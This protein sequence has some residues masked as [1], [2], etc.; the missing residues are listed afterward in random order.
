M[1]PAHSSQSGSSAN[2]PDLSASRDSASISVPSLSLPKGGG[3]LRGIGEKFSVNAC[4]GTGTTAVPLPFLPTRGELQPSL[5]LSY[6]SGS[7]NGSFGAGWQLDIGSIS[8]KTDKGLPKYEDVAPT[9]VFIFSGAEDLVPVLPENLQSRDGY[10]VRRFRPRVEAGFARIEWWVHSD[11]PSHNHWR[12][13][14]RDNVTHILGFST[15]ARIA[16][17]SDASR[18]FQWLLECSFNDRG[19]AVVY[20]YKPENFEGVDV[21]DLSEAHRLQGICTVA[22]SH[23]ESISYGNIAPF[24]AE[25]GSNYWPSVETL[26]ASAESFSE[27]WQFRAFFDYTARGLE[28]FKPDNSNWLAR[29]DP[30]SSYRAGFEVRSYRLCQKILFETSV[31]I[32]IEGRETGYAGITHALMLQY[33]EPAAGTAVNSGQ[34]SPILTKLESIQQLHARRKSAQGS[35]PPT[36]ETTPWPPLEFEYSISGAMELQQIS[37]ANAPALPEGIDGARYEWVDLDGEGIQGVLSRRN[38]AWWYAP[39]RWTSNSTPDAA[40]NEPATGGA[41]APQKPLRLQAAT[42]IGNATAQLVDLAGDGSL[43][44]LERSSG[45]TFFYERNDSGGWERPR[46]L[47]RHPAYSLDDPNLR[48]I[49]L[50]GDGLA[51]LLITE[52][53]CLVWQEALGEAGYGAVHRVA[54]VLDERRGP[55]CVFSEV[56]QTVF[57]ADLSGDGLTDIIRIRNGDVCYWPNLGYGRFGARVTMDYAPVFDTIDQFDPRRI[58]LLDADGSGMADLVYLGR[59][60]AAFWANQS[61][62][63][64]SERREIPFPIPHSLATVTA[65]DFFG[66]G[67]DCLVWSSPAP[68]DSA[69]HFQVVDLTGG[70]KPH[71]LTLV[72]NNM[73]AE[74]ALSYCSS[75]HFYLK[76]LADRKPWITRLPFPVHVIEAVETRDLIGRNHFVSRYAY[77][78]GY[79][80]GAEREFRGFGMVEQWDTDEIGALSSAGDA[81]DNWESASYVPPKLTRTWFHHGA[82]SLDNSLTAAFKTSYWDG[83]ERAIH[84]TESAIPEGLSVDEEREAHRALRGRMLRQEIYSLDADDDSAQEVR[85]R[86]ARPYETIEQNFTIRTLQPRGRNRHAVFFVHPREVLHAH[87]ER[88]APSD[89]RVAHALTLKVDAFGNVEQ[90]V[91]IGYGR[92]LPPKPD[93]LPQSKPD[94]PAQPKPGGKKDKPPPQHQLTPAETTAQNRTLLTLNDS[95]FTNAIENLPD[96]WRT[97]LPAEERTY[98]LTDYEWQNAKAEN[99]SGLTFELLQ[100]AV[101]QL[102]AIEEIAYEATASYAKRQLRLVE[103]HRTFYRSNDLKI[104]LPLGRLESLALPGEALKLALTPG[105]LDLYKDNAGSDDVSGYLRDRSA[106]YAEPEGDHHFWIPS[107]RTFFSPDASGTPQGSAA[108]LAFARKRFFLPHRFVDAFGNATWVAYDDA[109][110]RIAE[111]TDA[112]KNTT[113]ATYDY[114]VLQPRLLIDANDNYLAAAFDLRGLVVATAVLGQ[115]TPV[116]EFGDTLESLKPDLSP[117]EVDAFFKDPVGKA[118]DL[119]AGATTRFVYNVMRFYDADATEKAASPVFSATLERQFHVNRPF[120]NSAIAR[121]HAGLENFVLADHIQCRFSYSDGFGREIQRK[122]RTAPLIKDNPAQTKP[123]RWVGSGWTI[124]NNKGQPVRQYEPFFHEDQGAGSRPHDFEFRRTEGVSPIL[125][126]DPLGRVVATL[127]PDNSWEKVVFDPWLRDAW[128]RNDTVGNDPLNDPDV[129]AFFKRL[130]PVDWPLI[131]TASPTWYNQRTLSE[132]NDKAEWRPK[133]ETRA[134]EQTAEHAGTFTTTQFDT[135]GRE[136][137]VVTHNRFVD[138]R[139]NMAKEQFS[140]TRTVLDIEGNRLAVID[141]LGR[142]TMTWKYDMLGRPLQ[143]SSID[144]GSRWTLP[145]AASQPMYR[146]DERDHFFRH[147]YDALRRPSENWITSGHKS[148]DTHTDAICYE[149]LT[150]GEQ[151]GAPADANLRGRV[152]KH[153]DTAGLVTVGGY[154]AKGNLVASTRQFCRDY[155][156]TPDWSANPA[157]D[158]EPLASSTDFDALN[159]PIRLVTPYAS[160]CPTFRRYNVAGQLFGT[161]VRTAPEAFLIVRGI[162]YNARGQRRIVQYGN[163]HDGYGLR[164]TLSYDEKTFRLSSLITV[165]KDPGS[166]AAAYQSL[167][168][169]YDPVGNI[170]AIQDRAQQ[171]IYFKRKVVEPDAN[172]AYDALYRL[173]SAKGR[174]HI[175]QNLQPNLPPNA[176][177]SHRMGAF[178]GN[179]NFTSFA[180]PNDQK[181]MRIYTQRYAYDPVGNIEEMQHQVDAQTLWR[182]VYHYELV[183]GS[184]DKKSNKLIRTTIG[185]STFQYDYDAH[186]SMIT[187]PHLPKMETD[188]RDQL[189]LTMRQK[190]KCDA[191]RPFSRGEVTYYVYDGSGERAR[192]VTE[193][194]GKKVSERLYIGSSEIYRSYKANGDDLA[195]ERR[196]LH[197]SDGERRFALFETLTKGSDTA[198]KQLIRCQFPNHLGSACLET[199][200]EKKAPV[201]SYEEFHPFGTTAYQAVNPAIKAAAKRFRFTGKE[202]DEENGLNY[203]SARY[204]ATWLGRWVSADP[205]GIKDHINVYQY[206]QNDPIGGT[207]PTGRWTWGQAAV[208]GAVVAVSVAVTILTAGVGT[209]AVAAAVSAVGGGTTTAAATAFLGTVAVGTLTGAAGGAAADLTAQALS[210]GPIDTNRIKTAAISGGA[211][212]GILS[213]IPGVAAARATAQAVRTGSMAAQA[214]KATQS[215]TA[216]LGRQIAVSAVKGG[217]AGALGGATHE[218]ARQF[219]SGEARSLSDFGSMTSLQRPEQDWPLALAER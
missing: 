112:A 185:S 7:G 169:V 103:H 42:A 11:I 143:E 86:A 88:I 54:K 197:V 57:L 125:F 117:A 215:A 156:S 76:D 127:H 21:N 147:T 68:G 87:Y 89:P 206:A 67:T 94:V 82:W 216:S 49:D 34:G 144:A 52:D 161:T 136:F 101:G 65:A 158:T 28:H 207:D 120:A 124:F 209:V 22:G 192:K 115:S 165:D 35:N 181:A 25:G 198:A 141:A 9:D 85:E 183:A 44:V 64:W 186:G 164:T 202:R 4:T 194:D 145:D 163:N 2:E 27:H 107:G 204:L 81:A 3:A 58:R 77:H 55:R 93:D 63:S 116:G 19:S 102:D 172:Y 213:L 20:R 108:E 188:F 199:Q 73:G 176:W 193:F 39:N 5:T 16:D 135:L 205:E 140:H 13:I 29:R 128:D 180:N 167:D 1:R 154:D 150:Y 134:A 122:V 119:L 83:D 157:L 98:E 137:L 24:F 60:G 203:H 171:T 132:P 121:R 129:S 92:R 179:C 142:P 109:I 210:E 189:R 30:F 191:D 78:H 26:I 45:A 182:R 75:T 72:R 200:F 110:L 219:A 217:G 38:D 50:D 99:G 84:L 71:L 174:E 178:D 173:T 8:R 151:P 41:F 211:S 148:P 149:R 166:S 48:M 74:T 46:P 69:A 53:D 61:G 123:R 32:E 155:K 118:E 6:D 113:R 114:R 79:F 130:A 43:D 160:D 96:E 152:W 18:V 195:A 17:P 95:I 104:L 36:Y 208:V 91:A 214:I 105:L 126:Y 218:T 66:R 111:V 133:Q 106:G 14:S 190:V 138:P 40:P 212:G 10:L 70:I 177:D 59:K 56:N 31:S 153:H 168:Y 47:P 90:S 159:R 196:S 62:N 33:Q 37:P 184:R 187:M 23:L 15:D 162:D 175:G 80:D 100:D 131:G 97:P 146:W 201:I 170:T 51:E 12:V 139:S